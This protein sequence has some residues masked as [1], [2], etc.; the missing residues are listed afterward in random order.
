MNRPVR[1]D[2]NR[3]NLP[4]YMLGRNCR[5]DLSR[6]RIM[7]VLNV[8]PDSFYDG[9]RYTSEDHLRK[10]IDEML[11]EGVDLIDIGGESTR[12]GSL[13]VTAKKELE[14]VLPAIRLV[15]EAGDVPVSIDT[16]KAAVAAEAVAA[17][18]DF[19]N[20]ISGLQFDPEM[21]SAVGAS[22]AGLF[23]MHTRGRPE[24]M[25]KETSYRDIV[26]EVVAYLEAAVRQAE[27]AGVPVE[28]IAV[29][30]GIGFG[31]SVEGNLEL[32]HRLD[33][34]KILGFPI[35]LG[36]SRKSFIGKVLQEDNPGNRLAGSLATVA[37][38]VA[39]G[40]RIFRVHDVRQSRQAAAIAWA[41]SSA[42]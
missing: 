2:I 4:D 34:L 41:V 5:L 26:S 25:Q 15:R 30:P 7:G 27:D 14:R 37:L 31:K 24:T 29:D 20:D 22:G 28:K 38:G 36:T 12:P 39:A 11:A 35:L 9:G 3:N 21:A 10:R 8:T 19:V 23:L 17:G 33:E 16:T 18:A 40:A 1:Q 32:L 42:G 13:P 6:P